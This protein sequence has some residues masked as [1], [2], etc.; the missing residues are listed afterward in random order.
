M[1]FHAYS[2][3]ST[4]AF[5]IIEASEIILPLI[6]YL[7]KLFLHAEAAES[8]DETLLLILYFPNVSVKHECN[9]QEKAFLLHLIY[10]VSPIQWLF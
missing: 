9:S 3:E 6:I 5:L 4:T 8:F 2:S 7:N 1:Q 10:H